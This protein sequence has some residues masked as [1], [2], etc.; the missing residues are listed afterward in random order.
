M[1]LVVVGCDLKSAQLRMNI[2]Y[3]FTVRVHRFAGKTQWQHAVVVPFSS[4][5][6]A[7]HHRLQSYHRWAVD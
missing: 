5:T 7:M 6:L 1:A 2:L 3:S 4:V